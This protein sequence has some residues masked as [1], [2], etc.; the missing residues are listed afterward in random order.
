M[1][2]FL[3]LEN[4]SGLDKGE[5]VDP[6]SIISYKITKTYVNFF[7]SKPSVKFI[8]EVDHE[9]SM[10]Y[11]AAIIYAA[12]GCDGASVTWE[13]AE[14]YISADLVPDRTVVEDEEVLE[15]DEDDV[16]SDDKVRSSSTSGYEE[17]DSV[18]N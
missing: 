4:G 18:K 5:G 7:T 13:E 10:E 1:A 8:H 3:L 16:F 9:P 12:Q 15:A 14:R 6:S 11:I 2:R 17:S